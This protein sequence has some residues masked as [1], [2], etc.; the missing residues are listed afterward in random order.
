MHATPAPCKHAVP[1][2]RHGGTARVTHGATPPTGVHAA[3]GRHHRTR[4]EHGDTDSQVVGTDVWQ[5]HID[6]AAACV[7]HLHSGI[8]NKKLLLAYLWVVPRVTHAH[9]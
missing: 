9:S 7:I 3:C 8:R 6:Q 1:H 4:R 2:A 5:E